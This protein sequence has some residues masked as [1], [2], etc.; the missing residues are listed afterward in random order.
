MDNDEKM[1]QYDDLESLD[2]EIKELKKKRKI[3]ANNTSKEGVDGKKF[4]RGMGN[5]WNPVLWLK[6]ISSIF[7][8]RKLIIYTLIFGLVF[9]SGYFKAWRSKPILVNAKDTIIETTISEGIEKGD[10]LRIE[11][12]NG[13]M[14]Y[15]FR[16]K[17]GINSQRFPITNKDLPKLKPYGIKLKPK[18]F[19][20]FGTGG[21]AVGIGVELAHF[22]RF[23]LDLFGMSDKAIY[24]GVSYDL[25]TAS[26]GLFA[27]SSIGLALGQSMVNATD[28]RV[29]LYWSI[30]F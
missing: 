7:N 29:M 10:V 22:W 8:I 23:N 19:V 28:K 17:T 15:Q 3:L 12:K 2:T 11:I 25:D 20:G 1:K 21:P 26:D 27:N 6:D 13:R 14:Y 16:R 9:G 5:F 18:A 4:A 24:M 30:K